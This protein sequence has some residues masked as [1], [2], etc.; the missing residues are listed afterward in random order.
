MNKQDIDKASGQL[1]QAKGFFG[2]LLDAFTN[3]DAVFAVLSNAT[4]FK[5][6]LTIEVDALKASSEELKIQIESSKADISS[7][8]ESV[9]QAQ[10]E[11]AKSIADAKA[12]AAEQVTTIL[13]SIETKTKDAAAAFDA[14]QIELTAAAE[15]LKSNHD[16]NIVQAQIREAELNSSIVQ[17]EAK[18]D[19]LKAQAKK[20]AASLVE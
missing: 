9:A 10:K 19:S 17:L 14:K 15:E 16:S 7:N 13:A 12:N 6:H 18:L 2:P 5:D 4:V 8:I 11:A 3:A 20:F 1:A